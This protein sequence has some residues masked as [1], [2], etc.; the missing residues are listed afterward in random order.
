MISFKCIKDERWETEDGSQIKSF[1]IRS[2][3]ILTFALV[4]V[5]AYG[6][7][8][9][10]D[11]IIIAV[12]E[13]LAGDGS[14]TE[15]SEMFIEKLYDLTE[16][17]VLINSGNENELRRLFFLS[18]FQIR[19]LYDYIRTAGRIVSP[20]EIANIPGF[21]RETVELMLP[22]IS[23]ENKNMM[24]IDSVKW[25]N[26]IIT[27]FYIRPSTADSG[28]TGSPWKIL[29]KYKFTAGSFSGGFT[30]EKDPGEKFINSVTHSPDFFSGFLTYQRTGMI[31]RIIV[32]DFSARFGQGTNINTGIRTGLSL[33]T[34]GYLSGKNEV[35][36]YTSTDENNFFRGVASEFSYKNLDLSIFYSV[37]KLDA[38]L[39]D[40]GESSDTYIKS[41][42][43]TG[44]HNTPDLLL[45]KDVIKETCYSVNI[46]YNFTN[47]RMGMVW[48]ENRFSKPVK[49]ENMK[50]EDIYDFEGN[51]NKLYTIYYNNLF[52]RIILSGELSLN[53][54][55]R[56]AVMQSVSMRPGD[57]L[58]INVLYLRYSPGFVSFH[59]NGPGSTG[60]NNERGVFGNF[61]YEAAK[62]LFISAGCDIRYFPWLKYRCDAPSWGKRQEVRIKYL[63]TG[64]VTIDAS[65]NYK[66]N[67]V[68]RSDSRG[69]QK[70]EQLEIRSFKGFVKYSPNDKITLGTR[71]DYK[72]ADPSASKGTLLLQDF[73]YRFSSVPVS[74][75]LRYCIF[76]TTDYESRIYTWENDL[77][78]SFSIPAFYGDGSRSF[79]M[80]E[81]KI[82]K[83]AILR[84]KYSISTH[85]EIAQKST[86]I[87]EFR[88]QFRINI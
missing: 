60:S 38:S 51:R 79:I 8:D 36:P 75:W 10:I 72:L 33:T 32:G 28:L 35:K 67:M 71:I 62:F 42:Y 56:S 45:K 22:F 26:N 23:F 6:Q 57:R 66:S 81:W 25:R 78:Y 61:T 21:D 27:N 2:F 80:A 43:K 18:D 34:P 70:Q 13:E 47:L 11:E 74:L 68:N 65:Y 87:E 58:N 82:C 17:P 63:S 41:F 40:P 77:L 73:N 49:I 52:R 19:V 55:G 86:D 53:G 84:V 50:P 76:N 16:E 12:A 3:Q 24:G 15:V 20:F 85:L 64:P 1:F 88:F 69:I 54:H 46:S 83:K 14:G 4:P 5:F 29:T 44:L 39:N 59:G 37:N 31:R 48:S 30:T 7:A 9:R